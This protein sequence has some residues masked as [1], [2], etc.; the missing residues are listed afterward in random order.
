MQQHAESEFAAIHP[1]EMP[2]EELWH[3]YQQSLSYF[4]TRIMRHSTRRD[5][6]GDAEDA[7]QEI[8][9]KVH[10]SLDRFDGSRS[11]SAWVYSIARN[12]CLD[13]RR[14]RTIPLAHNAPADLDEMPSTEAD[15]PERILLSNELRRTVDTFMSTLSK[16]NRSILF[17]RF[18][19]DLPYAEIAEVIGRPEGTVRY[20]VH[21]LKQ[22]L[23]A[24]LEERQ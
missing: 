14:R 22:Q 15:D 2:F 12:H 8:M 18:Y 5:L 3:R 7:V 17:L 10:R 21:E 23:K 4:V 6:S 20:R 24:Y 11:L 9:F 13:L 16:E 19:E 1:S